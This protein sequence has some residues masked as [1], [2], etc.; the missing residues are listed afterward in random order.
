MMP[1]NKNPL[2]LVLGLSISFFLVFVAASA[3]IY[4]SKPKFLKGNLGSGGEGLVAVI[5]L[6]G[7]IFDSKKILKKFED[8]A[9]DDE[10]KAIVLRINSPGGAVAP[11]Q[12]I[13][14]VVK[15]YKKPVIASIGSLGA[16]GGYYI[17]CG[18]KKIFANPGSLTGSIGVIMEFANLEKLYDWAK[19]KRYSIKTGKFKDTGAEYR[20]MTS[21]DKALLQEMVDDV[22]VQFK[23]AVAEG[24][25]LSL[26]QVS[27]VADGRIFSGNQAKTAK[28]VDELGTLQDAVEAAAKLAHIN[29][30]PKVVY[31]S[32]HRKKF[33][34]YL[35]EDNSRDEADS[36][37]SLSW[38]GMLAKHFL[39]ESAQVQFTP[40]VYWLWGG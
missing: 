16:S 11:S 34:D 9:D 15:K 30:K 13:Y 22:L 7:V 20:D 39:G 14:E 35:L 38:V 37:Q 24:R 3:L 8:Y 1:P 12:E 4:F 10:V 18:A 26:A 36:E 27:L 29:G 6:N 33:L 25:K 28:L 2:A 32:K 5:E 40:G 21:E 17:A 23:K 31:P 19:I